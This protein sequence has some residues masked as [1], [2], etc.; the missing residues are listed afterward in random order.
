M[1]PATGT[2]LSPCETVAPLGAGGMGEVYRAR[3]MR[4]ARDIALKVLPE[5]FASDPER[6]ARFEREAKTLAALNH[7]HIAQ[8]YGFEQSGASSAPSTR[9]AENACGRSESEASSPRRPWPANGKVYFVSE[10]GETVVL[11]AG[12][13]LEVLARNTLD[14][15]FV[16]S[17]AITG[18]L[19]YLRADDAL[20]A[21][22]R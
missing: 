14:G 1:T 19:P 15:H 3:D 8:A 5:L 9:V 17:P 12:R 2:R 21:V 11:R 13:T 20:I 22:G 16:A 7:P 18:G 6:L 4:L 10:T